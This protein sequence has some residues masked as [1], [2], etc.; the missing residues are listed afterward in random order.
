MSEITVAN[1]C[2]VPRYHLFPALGLQALG[3]GHQNKKLLVWV[4]DPPTIPYS[5][6]LVQHAGPFL[7]TQQNFTRTHHSSIFGAGFENNSHDVSSKN[8]ILIHLLNFFPNIMIS[9]SST[10]LQLFV[11]SKRMELYIQQDSH[12]K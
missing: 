8:R 12:I 9:L 6:L 10:L 7:C 1:H 5:S 3:V 11:V 2:Y 4:T